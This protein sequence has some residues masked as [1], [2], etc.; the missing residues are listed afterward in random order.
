M[1]RQK[2]SPTS[3]IKER[4]CITSTR[5][6]ASRTV[7]RPLIYDRE[8]CPPTRHCFV[9][10][11]LAMTERGRARVVVHGTWHSPRPSHAHRPVRL[12][13]PPRPHRAARR[14]A[15]G[16]GAAARCRGGGAARS[17]RARPAAAADARRRSEG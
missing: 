11:F 9:T 16:F 10:P 6:S 13:S 15:A 7:V 3:D 4:N 5:A 14:R 2:K 1:L 17:G 8:S 12:Q